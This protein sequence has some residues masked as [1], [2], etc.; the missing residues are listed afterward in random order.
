M[1]RDFD[2]KVVAPLAVDHFKRV[3][4]VQN[5]KGSAP[6]VGT[7]QVGIERPV[8]VHGLG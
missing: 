2:K 7:V 5:I 4:T 6:D 1:Q 8:V 3:Q